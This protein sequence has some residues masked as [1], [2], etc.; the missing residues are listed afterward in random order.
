MPSFDSIKKDI[1]AFFDVDKL[2]YLGGFVV[3]GV[4]IFVLIM[5]LTEGD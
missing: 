3:V 5:A 2:L 1:I 4:V